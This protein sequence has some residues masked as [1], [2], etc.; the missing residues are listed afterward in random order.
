MDGLQGQLLVA[1]SDLLDPNFLR[2]VVLIVQHSDEGTLGLILD[3]RTST[4]LEQMWE[5]IGQTPCERD[6]KLHLGGP[7]S[8]PLMAVH[9]LANAS[10]VEI[11]EGLYFSAGTEALRVLAALGDHDVRFFVGHAGWG[12][13][14]LE[15]EIADGSWQLTPATIELVFS[16]TDDLW[17]RATRQIVGSS[18]IAA[19]QIKHVPPH[20]NLN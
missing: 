12:A 11:N 16:G 14:Q 2:T 9:T 5:Q 17:L 3:R 6:E 4:S 8:G 20:P 18:L 13:G 7:V 19:L 10:E 1:S 15:G